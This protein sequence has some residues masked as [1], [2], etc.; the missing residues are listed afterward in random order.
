MLSHFELCSKSTGRG[1]VSK[2][3]RALINVWHYQGALLFLETPSLPVDLRMQKGQPLCIR[4]SVSSVSFYLFSITQTLTRIFAMKKRG[5]HSREEKALA[6]KSLLNSV[7]T[8]LLGIPRGAKRAEI[9]LTDC[10]MSALEQCLERN[11]RLFSPLT[12]PNWRKTV[13][14]NLKTL[15]S[16]NRVP[17]DT[18]M[19]QQLPPAAGVAG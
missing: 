2:N 18:R 14:H 5:P 11:R 9:S 7:R 13:Q 19:R 3:K 15:Y 17:S 8:V 12:V 10:L 4:G 1:G 6:A 16:V